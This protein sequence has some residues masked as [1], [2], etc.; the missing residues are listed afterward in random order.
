MNRGGAPRTTVTRKPTPTRKPKKEE[1]QVEEEAHHEVQDAAD[2]KPAARARHRRARPAQSPPLGTGSA[3]QADKKN[4]MVPVTAKM[5]TKPMHWSTY[6]R[7]ANVP[8]RKT[9][10]MRMWN[11][12]LAEEPKRPR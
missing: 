4:P 10:A 1:P 2:A 8:K 6:P 7:V 11:A 12:F 9:L 5:K 3:R